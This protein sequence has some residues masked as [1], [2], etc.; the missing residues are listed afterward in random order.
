MP[1]ECGAVANRGLIEWLGII[2]ERMKIIEVV[3]MV[4]LVG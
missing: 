3:K 2:L 1:D 4:E